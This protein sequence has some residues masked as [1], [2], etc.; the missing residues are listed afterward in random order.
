MLV[1]TGWQWALVCFAAFLIGVSKT[2]IAGINILA[3][4]VFASVLPARE[5]VGAVLIAFLAADLVAVTAYRHDAE[6]RHLWRLFPW[7]GLG[8]VIGALAMGRIPDAGV[9]RMIGGILL[10]L[11]VIYLLRQ[12]SSR[13]DEGELVPFVRYP[14]LIGLTG[15]LAGFTTMVANAS[16]PIM[17][18]Y[19][20]ALRL[21]KLAFIGTAAW[22][23][24][25]LN[26][27][28]VPF[29]AGLGLINANSLAVSLRLIP[30][31]V[32]GA[33][34]GKPLLR[35]VDQKLFER[36]ALALTLVAAVRL[37]L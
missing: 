7:A 30:F 23:F 33:L 24:F 11:I 6:W 8:V 5:S 3:I 31:A 13:H 35:R 36:L 14:W 22:F 32:A 21:P 37:L 10:V 28:K 2:G 27:F 18:L 26:L 15:I 16:G 25:A 20:L 29:S 1:L 4:A 9:R 12:Y 34:V 17:I 19:L